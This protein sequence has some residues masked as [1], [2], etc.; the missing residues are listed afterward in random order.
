MIEA[1]S[2]EQLVLSKN[3]Y[4][5]KVDL[6]WYVMLSGVAD[7]WEMNETSVQLLK[8]FSTKTTV[9]A[10]I[11]QLKKRFEI[12]ISIENELHIFINAM[13]KNGV[14]TIVS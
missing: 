13:I 1:Q 11:Y 14:L 6:T 10:A 4:L 2:D 8:C 5:K 9:E 7:I 12:P 3:A